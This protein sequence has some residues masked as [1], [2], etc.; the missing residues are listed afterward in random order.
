MAEQYAPIAKDSSLNTTENT[1][2]NLADVLADELQGI[3]NAVKPTA[4]DIPFD[5]TGTSLVADDVQGA[6]EEV[7]N[8]SWTFIANL[9]DG[10]TV[11]IDDS[12]YKELLIIPQVS[13]STPYSSL[14]G[15]LS[16][17][18]HYMSIYESNSNHWYGRVT[19]NSSTKVFKYIQHDLV[20][21]TKM[22]V[23]VYTK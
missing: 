12:V 22:T 11:N 3:A 18:G 15:L 13:G 19:Y 16:N 17:A 7:N 21:W 5:N 23:K 14:Y 2:R 10:D 1:P 9:E 20:G 6:I 8:K 4:S